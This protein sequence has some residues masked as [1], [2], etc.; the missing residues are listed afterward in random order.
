M[1][2]KFSDLSIHIVYVNLAPREDRRAETQYQLY[3]H[4][5]KAERQPGVPASRVRDTWGFQNK[6]RY[7]CSL[8]KRLA[9][10]RGGQSGAEAVLLLEDDI[11]IHPDFRQRLADLELPD[12][13][14]ILFLGCRHLQRPHPAGPGLVRCT[15]ATDNHAVLFRRSSIRQ[16]LRGLR[17]IRRG[18]PPTIPFSDVKLSELQ[19]EIPSYAAYPNLIWQREN[20]SDGSA[21]KLGHYALDG[22]QLIFPEMMA[23][24]DREIELGRPEAESTQ[25][26]GEEDLSTVDSPP[27]VQSARTIPP[28]AERG[29][30]EP[31]GFQ[32]LKDAPATCRFEERFP[33]RTYINLSRREDRR[34]KVSGVFAK[35]GLSVERFAAVDGRSVKNPRG[36][37]LPNVYACRLSHRIV[38]RQARQR[39]ESAVLICEDDVVLHKHFRRLAEAL[40]PPEDWGIIFLG[41]THVETPHVVAPAWVKVAGLWSLQAYA[42][43]DV[44]FNTVLHALNARG[45]EGREEGADVV[46]SRLAGQ[47][48]MYAVYPNIAWQEDGFSDLM[49]KDR[50]P[51][52]RD[53]QQNRLRHVLRPANLAMRKMIEGQFGPQGPPQEFLRPEAVYPAG[54]TERKWRMEEVL[55]IRRYIN[56]DSRP[57]RKS[58]IEAQMSEQTLEV[59]RFP[60]KC[61]TGTPPA[62]ALRG[63]EWGCALSHA[64]ILEAA[65]EAGASGVLIFE[66]DVVLHPQFR[67]WCEAV[68]LPEDWAILYF[69]CQHTEMPVEITAPGLVR[70]TGAY[71]THAYAVRGP[72][73]ARAAAVIRKGITLG[74]PCD[75]ALA[76]LQ[77]EVPAYA[78][79]PNLA[80]QAEGQSDIKQ[81]FSRGYGPD[82]VQRWH[83]P[84]LRRLD[85]AMR[86]L[87]DS[88]GSRAPDAVAHFSKKTH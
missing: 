8:A 65:H 36:H 80:W 12:D 39:K 49:G 38:L 83:Q 20:W 58:S 56:L 9:V 30:D 76:G 81:A 13:W 28:Q 27:P 82:G 84:V 64:S 24:L 63:G 60:A 25:Q 19:Q 73:L 54:Q 87:L 86:A 16:V 3:L 5:L 1:P 51:F 46:L 45:V 2:V 34:K 14:Q 40:P 21:R 37:G 59:E 66:D 4:D 41:C 74:I 62:V 79:Y 42:V 10:R 52:R 43:K 48:P 11:V 70:C 22:R 68:A 31:P 78:F 29:A 7:A 23:A 61:P 67:K 47:I 57:D 26:S 50:Q 75:V 18:A 15:Q 33:M 53:G 85:Q 6:S 35:Q 32:F 17:G 88:G 44:Y 72:W 55:P 77:K 71:S 69:G